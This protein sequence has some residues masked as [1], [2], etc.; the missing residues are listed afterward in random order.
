MV[1]AVQTFIPG[2]SG[3][4]KSHIDGTPV[5]I[6]EA[7]DGFVSLPETFIPYSKLMKGSKMTMAGF[8]TAFK[9]TYVA[10]LS[11]KT[12]GFI[13]QKIINQPIERM[14]NIKG[15]S[16]ALGLDPGK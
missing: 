6:D 7:V 8:N 13:L 3:S 4:R 12:K 15:F 9:G 2:L 14:S 5:T 11:P 16:K 10:K 1:Y